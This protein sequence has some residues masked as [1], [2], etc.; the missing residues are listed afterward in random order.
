MR[1]QVAEEGGVLG[2]S[3][4]RGWRSS[5]EPFVQG[6]AGPAGGACLARGAFGRSVLSLKSEPSAT[7]IGSAPQPTT[8]AIGSTRC[9]VQEQPHA[10]EEG[11]RPSPPRGLP[12]GPAPGSPSTRA[13]SMRA[14]DPREPVEVHH[15]DE[16]ARRRRRSPRR[17]PQP[18]AAP[19]GEHDPEARDTERWPCACADRA[20]GRSAVL[21]AAGQGRSLRASRCCVEVGALLRREGGEAGDGAH[22]SSPRS[23]RSAR[24]MSACMCFAAAKIARNPA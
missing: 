19:I 23:R 24:S 14:H 1:D 11:R 10:A 4:L 9:D 20:P 12:R 5:R 18:A 2:H 16:R 13:P 6:A 15:R 21:V 7:P 8:S 3:I 17:A 22:G